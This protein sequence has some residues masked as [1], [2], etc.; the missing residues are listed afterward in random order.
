M[1]VDLWKFAQ[2]NILLIAVAAASGGMLLWP[3]LRGDGGGGT[4]VNTLEATLLIN[5]QDAQVID[6]REAEEYA[7]GHIVNARNVPHAELE[8]RLRELEKYKRKPVIVCCDR[9]NRSN[10]AT[11][12]LRKNGFD[13]AVSL[14]R[15]LE[16]W[17]VAGL[18]LEKA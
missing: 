10:A 11:A 1:N 4:S 8:S 17:R 9:G 6:L 16:G 12:L 2:D 13:K 7:K 15:G 18:P 14:A 3:S 5:Q